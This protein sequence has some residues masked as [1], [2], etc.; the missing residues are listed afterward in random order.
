MYLLIDWGN[1]RLKFLLIKELSEFADQ[2]QSIESDTA[3]SAKD[4]VMQ[5]EQYGN[6]ESIVKVLIASVRNDKDNQELATEL[7]QIG[8]TLFIAKTSPYACGVECAYQNP[9][10]LGI[11]RWLAMIAGYQ[12]TNREADQ[13]VGILDIG[14]AIT[15]DIIDPEG[16]HL[17]GH[18]LPGNR[19]LSES[20]LNTANVRIDHNLPASKG[21]ELGR[22][23]VDCVNFGV[24]QMIIGYLIRAMTASNLK[25]KVNQWI[26]TGGGSDHWIELLQNS[27]L[28][29]QDINMQHSLTLVFQGLAK[30]YLQEE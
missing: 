25:Y 11:D 28:F 4:L 8:L 1:T 3:T 18:I 21:F 19:L 13:T 5:L 17:G 7:N 15:L 6:K 27:E 30:L 14:S 20:L 24:E 23:T 10:K 22:S 29:S 26:I 16:R 2:Q 12:T 9:Q